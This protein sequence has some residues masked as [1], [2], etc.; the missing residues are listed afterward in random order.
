KYFGLIRKD[1]NT[2]KLIASV[3][4]QKAVILN[5]IACTIGAK[6]AIE[7]AGGIVE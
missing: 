3:E 1:I 7:K 6:E 4:I 5:G 2:V